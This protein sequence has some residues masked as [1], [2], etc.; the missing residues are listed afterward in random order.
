M[1]LVLGQILMPVRG[2]SRLRNALCA[3]TSSASIAAA[4]TRAT[5]TRTSC[6]WITACRAFWGSAWTYPRTSKWT[7]TCGWSGRSSPSLFH[8]KNCYSENTQLSGRSSMTYCIDHWSMHYYNSNHS[9]SAPPGGS[10]KSSR[11]GLWVIVPL[12]FFKWWAFLT[13]TPADFLSGK[14]LNLASHT[15]LISFVIPVPLN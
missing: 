13:A 9:C 2:T 12:S 15:F 8:G 7:T 5:A 4:T 11:C 1:S 3:P 6:P 10:K 14:V